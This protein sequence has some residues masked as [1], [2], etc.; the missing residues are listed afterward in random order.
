M[1]DVDSLRVEIDGDIGSLKSALDRAE[2]LMSDSTAQIKGQLERMDQTSR[3]IWSKIG[4]YGAIGFAAWQ[5]AANFL[6]GIVSAVRD[7]GDKMGDLVDASERLGV[8]VEALQELNFAALDVGL[9]ASDLEGAFDK[10]AIKAADG[11]SRFKQLGVSLRNADGSLRSIEDIF[12]DV[13]RKA[14]ALTSEQERL[15]VATDLFGKSAGPKMV[16]MLNQGGDGIDALRQKARDLGIVMDESLVRQGDEAAKK[17]EVLAAVMDNQFTQALI[18]LAPIITSVLG[19]LVELVRDTREEI[20]AI[21]N[22]IERLGNLDIG[23]ARGMSDEE[24]GAL[25]SD[26]QRQIEENKA[27]LETADGL[28]RNFLIEEI[29]ML[30]AKLADLDR[31]MQS[32]STEGSAPAPTV[33]ARPVVTLP[34]AASRTARTS[35]GDPDAEVRR[36]AETEQNIAGILREADA[37]QAEAAA[38]GE[39][40]EAY[41]RWRREADLANKVAAY[42]EKL[43]AALARSEGSVAV[44]VDAATASYDRALRAADAAAQAMDEGPL[45]DLKQAFTDA[46]RDLASTLVGAL[47]GADVDG[48]EILKRLSGRILE[49]AFQIQLIDPML[50]SLGLGSGGSSSGGTDIWGLISQGI[51]LISGLGGGSYGSGSYTGM[52]GNYVHR[53]AGGR[54]SPDAA[55]QVGEMGPEIFVPDSPGRILSAQ[56]LRGGGGRGAMQ[57]THAPTYNIDA[58]GSQMSE[59]Q[60]RAIL[61]ENNRQQAASLRRGFGSYARQYQNERG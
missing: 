52:E 57:V 36:Q 32:R 23:S 5:G 26:Y 48:G 12:G 53:A 54:V 37:L 24:I 16:L 10:L 13:V 6:P 35:T 45:Q 15:A 27:R 43:I 25:R 40:A 21:V 44:D 41:A 56:D 51:G 55:Y 29:R 4:H 20:E 14:G 7:A 2:R 17:L 42:R 3:Q 31:I 28:Q 50:K 33:P 1:T 59:A 39:G 61:E 22:F 9:S 49:L 30:E 8:G 38:R 58:R 46:G 60:F 34:P 18:E 11:D 19:G 47:Q